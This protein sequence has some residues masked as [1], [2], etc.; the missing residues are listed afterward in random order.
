M[1][2]LIIQMASR[3]LNALQLCKH[4]HLV[5]ISLFWMIFVGLEKEENSLKEVQ[6]QEAG[7]AKISEHLNR[8]N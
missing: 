6:I 1:H 3:K 8:V 2:M 7:K 5:N 4:P